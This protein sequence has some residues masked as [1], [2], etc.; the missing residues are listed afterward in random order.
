MWRARWGPTS[1]RGIRRPGG[2]GSAPPAAAPD[3]YERLHAHCDVLVVGGGP[4]GLAAA[5]AA[6]RRGGR[7]ML[8]DERGRL[9]GSLHAA[10]VQ[11][12]DGVPAPQWLARTGAEAAGAPRGTLVARAAPVRHHQ[13]QP[14]A[15]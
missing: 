10:S 15:R 9:G 14:L 4:A 3:T 2:R 5:L 12:I 11:A 7:V 8:A 1:E 6:A 13:L